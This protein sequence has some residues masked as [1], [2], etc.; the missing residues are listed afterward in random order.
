MDTPELKKTYKESIVPELMKNWGY[1]NL[2]QVPGIDRVVINTGI[3]G[4]DRGVIQEV[5]DQLSAIA[6]Q[7]AVVTKARISVSNFKLRAGM[8]IGAKV[9]LR[10]NAMWDFVYRLLNIALPAIRDFRGVP[11]KMDGHGNYTLGITDITIFPEINVDGQKRTTGLDITFVTTADTDEEG[12][13]LLKLLGMPFR[14]S[15]S[16]QSNEAEAVASAAM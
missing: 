6:G 3:G 2:H 10:G 16:T 14:K 1:K 7:R 4:E 11:S 15:T 8:P 12:A 9:D 5:T 13:E